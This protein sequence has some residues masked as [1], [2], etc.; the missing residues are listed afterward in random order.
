MPP[1]D[2][3]DHEATIKP[4]AT[5]RRPDARSCGSSQPVPGPSGASVRRRRPCLDTDRYPGTGPP[6]PG[7]PRPARIGTPG[8]S[9]GPPRTGPS[10]H[11]TT[12]PQAF[13]SSRPLCGRAVPHGPQRGHP[14]P[15]RRRGAARWSPP[16]RRQPHPAGGGVRHVLGR[17]HARRLVRASARPGDPR[18]RGARHRVRPGVHRRAG[19]RLGRAVP[20]RAPGRIVFLLSF[21]VLD[22]MLSLAFLCW[23][24]VSPNYFDAVDRRVWQLNWSPAAK[25]AN[26]AGVVGALA[27]G[28]TP[29]RWS[30]RSR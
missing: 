3:R 2:G 26:T 30:W 28:R 18:R 1:V 29:S 17:R 27:L 25:A 4:A 24:V 19:R 11:D 9:A 6:G 13:A 23:P 15:H 5:A 12:P 21:M 14:G 20:A 8:G 10:C 22:T 7:V 16:C